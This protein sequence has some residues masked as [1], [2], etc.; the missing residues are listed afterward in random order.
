VPHPYRSLRRFAGPTNVITGI[1]RAIS[2]LLSAQ[3][4]A[5]RARAWTPPAARFG[6]HGTRVEAIPFLLGGHGR[7]V[8]HDDGLDRFAPR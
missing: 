4:R 6:A 7:V 8:A 2:Y 5:E 3:H 1:G